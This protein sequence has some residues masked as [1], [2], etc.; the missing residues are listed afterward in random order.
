MIQRNVYAAMDAAELSSSVSDHFAHRWSDYDRQIRQAIPSYDFVLDLLVD[1]VRRGSSPPMSIVDAGIGTGQLAARLLTA[2]PE[3]R[4]IG[5]DIVPD[6]L[7]LAAQRLECY[8]QRV[9]LIEG[10]LATL[11]LPDGADLYVTSFALHH[12]TDA[13]KQKVYRQMHAGLRADG[14][15]VNV[16]FVDSPSRYYSSL[17][18]QMRIELM[19]A[20]GMSV[21]E[22]DD[23]YVRHR[24]LEIPTS[25][26]RQMGWLDSIGCC[27]V[28]CFW[29]YL[30]LA[31][32]GGRK[33]SW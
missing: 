3:A 26:V 4:L 15:I 16:D 23:R 21:A 9:A 6:Y 5:I 28:E 27:D 7:E 33:R 13:T 12:M 11:E 1:I 8:S 17:F 22:I 19:R 32:F 2:F 10:D 20:E 14:V 25:L 24:Q 18:D 31:M 30:N 29:K